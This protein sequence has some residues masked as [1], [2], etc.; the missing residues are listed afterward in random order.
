M[1]GAAIAAVA[2]VVKEWFT[3]KREEAKA[4]HE[5]KL[6]VIKT[7]ASWEELMANASATSWKEIGRAHV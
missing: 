6:E 5:Q 4:K 3:N 7:T 2:E 1:W